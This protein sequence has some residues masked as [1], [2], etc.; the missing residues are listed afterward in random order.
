MNRIRMTDIAND[1]YQAQDDYDD[2]VVEY[3]ASPETAGCGC[4]GCATMCLIGL[5]MLLSFTMLR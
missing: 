1:D 2:V 3:A 4:L 5:C